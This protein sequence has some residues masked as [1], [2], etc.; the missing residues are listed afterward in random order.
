MKYLIASDIHGSEHWCGELIKTLNKE[1][2]DKIILLGDILYHGP[3][4]DLPSE[5]MPKKVI[6]NLN[7]LKDKILICMKGN[8]DAEV[9]EMVLDFPLIDGVSMI[10]IGGRNI[11]LTHGH[12]FNADPDGKKLPEGFKDG[13]ILLHGH[14]HI[15]TAKTVTAGGISLKLLNPGS[16]SIPKGGFENSYAVLDDD[17]IFS[18]RNFDQKEIMSTAL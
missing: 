2:A 12:R 1:K 13:D 16:T 6:E 15:P 8:C 5:Y 7:A 3:R 10:E 14:T 17:M 18:V 11:Y 4:N 9:D